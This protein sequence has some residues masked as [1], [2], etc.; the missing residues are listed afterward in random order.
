MSHC[1]SLYSLIY[2]RPMKWYMSLFRNKAELQYRPTTLHQRK[3]KVT[4]CNCAQTRVGLHSLATKAA[5]VNSRLSTENSSVITVS[6]RQTVSEYFIHSCCKSSLLFRSRRR[7]QSA[8]Q[9]RTQEFEKWGAT[10]PAPSLPLLSPSLPSPPPFPSPPS[11]FLCYVTS[12]DSNP[13][14]PPR[15]CYCTGWA[16]KNRTLCFSLFNKN[17]LMPCVE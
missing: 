15:R 8:W 11:P 1:H 13:C 10:S 5:K 4:Q 3:V 12:P 9:G 14:S 2:Y 7:N 6:V 17:W 16:N